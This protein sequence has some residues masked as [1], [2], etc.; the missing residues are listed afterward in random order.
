MQDSTQNSKFIVGLTGGIGSGKSTVSEIFHDQGI[1]V[2]DADTIARDLVIPDTPCFKAIVEHFGEDVL[3]TNGTLN[4]AYLRELIFNDD[5]QKKW[6]ES[7]LHPAIR[8]EIDRQISESKSA[9]IILSVPLLIESDQYDFVDR[10]LVIDVPEKTQLERIKA[11]D[12][13]SEKLIREIMASQVSRERRLAVADDTLDNS[14]SQDTLRQQVLL[15]HEHY[16]QIV[17]G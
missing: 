10:V 6:L 16:L 7:L 15:L 2:I 4:R 11:R 14:G 3:E 1:Q 13:S 12:A 17:N 9:Y 8:E 5:S